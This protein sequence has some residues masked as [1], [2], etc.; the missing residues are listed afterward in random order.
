MLKQSVASVHY[1][2]DNLQAFTVSSDGSMIHA[3][4]YYE[5]KSRSWID[6]TKDALVL[7]WHNPLVNNTRTKPSSPNNSLVELSSKS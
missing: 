3:Y 2:G 4:A 5:D 7:T 6:L 1:E